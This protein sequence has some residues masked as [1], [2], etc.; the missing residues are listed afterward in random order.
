[1]P[2]LGIPIRTANAVVT[3]LLAASFETSVTGKVFREYPIWDEDF[4]GLDTLRVSVVYVVHAT[5]VLL[6]TQNSIQYL[7]AIDICIRKRFGIDDDDD[8]TG[9]LLLASID[10]LVYLLEQIHEHFIAER[11]SIPLDDETTAKWLEA[12]IKSWVNLKKLRKG[13]FEG[14][15]R[16]TFSIRK[17]I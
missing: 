6:D 17:T 12:D 4:K 15:V 5:E 16:I 2:T 1:M 13:L 7:P 9:K 3:E 14:V 8:T 10:P 11:N